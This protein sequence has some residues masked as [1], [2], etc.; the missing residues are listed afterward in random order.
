[1]GA[2][3]IATQIGS[4][5]R[6]RRYPVKGMAG[7]ELR[8]A[9]VSFAGITGDRIYAFSDPAGP[10]DFP[11][12]TARKWRGML[13]LQPRFVEPPPAQ[14]RFADS[15]LRV[16]VTT[17]EG[18]KFG[19]DEQ[20]F[21]EYLEKKFGHVLRFHFTERSIQDARP[22][23]IFGTSTIEAL[24][25][26]TGHALEMRRFRSNL[27]VEWNDAA[28]F[29][30]DKLIGRRVRIGETVEVMP[31]KKD[32]RCVIITLD[33]DTAAATPEVLEVVAR[34]HEGCAGVY[35]VVLREGV[36]RPGDPVFVE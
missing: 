6:V 1:M 4:L 28:P 14:E 30:E 16:E 22:I 17:P 19:V 7:E 29:F 10:A 31:V 12:M 33:P 18:E 26:E 20:R 13:L 8:E 24:S 27:L 25:A 5:K 9:F 23:S 15:A 11:W 36:I 34:K 32:G 35:A 3:E 21:R 2:S